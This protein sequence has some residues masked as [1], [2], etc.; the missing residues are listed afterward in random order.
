MCAD[1]LLDS[2][3][4]VCAFNTSIHPYFLIPAIRQNKPEHWIESPPAMNTADI[5]NNTI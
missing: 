1:V 2:Q 3:S 5:Q 4:I